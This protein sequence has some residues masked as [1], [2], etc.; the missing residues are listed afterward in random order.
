MGEM[1][2]CATPSGCWGTPSSICTR[3]GLLCQLQKATADPTKQPWV[4]AD[5]VPLERRSS[6][7]LP[8]CAPSDFWKQGPQRAKA[9]QAQANALNGPYNPMAAYAHAIGDRE[10]FEHSAHH[11]CDDEAGSGNG[12]GHNDTDREG[13]LTCSQG[14]CAD[15]APPAPTLAGDQL[16]TGYIISIVLSVILFTGFLVAISAVLVLLCRR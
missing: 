3:Q 9:L 4:A 7:K 5:Y 10:G 12:N 15:D 13:Y 16:R 8:T 1:N 14:K 6:V 11:F 2:T